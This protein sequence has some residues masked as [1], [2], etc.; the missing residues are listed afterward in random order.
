MA[1]AM[2]K[3][4]NGTIN[5]NSRFRKISP[6]GLIYGTAEG[7]KIPNSAPNRSP[8]TKRMVDL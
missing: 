1:V 4:T 2:E 3:N 7:R 6:I 5:I 8:N